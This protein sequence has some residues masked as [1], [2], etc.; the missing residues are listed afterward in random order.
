MPE[1]A[2]SHINLHSDGA[3]A[4]VTLD[5]AEKLHALTPEMMER[6][7]GIAAHSAYLGGVADRAAH[8]R[9]GMEQTLERL[10]VA[11]EASG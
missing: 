4:T 11:A 6:L 8:N 3:V 5:R 1:S 2:T 9:S 10:A 7:A